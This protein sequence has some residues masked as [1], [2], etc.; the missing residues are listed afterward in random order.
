MRSVT[1]TI[2]GKPFAKQRARVTRFGAYTPKETVSFERAVGQ[3]AAV[4]FKQPMAGPVK[5]TVR[6]V[7]EPP[8]SWP[9][10]KRAAAMGR[11]HIIKPDLDN[12]E[13]AISDG[14]N[15]IAFADDSQVAVNSGIKI[16]GERAGTII[17]VEA[18]EELP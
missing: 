1:L 16:W 6:A 18:V 2:P 3:L 10:K 12:I 8:A 15:R 5:L 9:A 13:K 14:L 11:C 17:T 4:H 7:F